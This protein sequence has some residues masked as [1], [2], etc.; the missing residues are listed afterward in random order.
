MTDFE[1]NDA[2]RDTVLPTLQ[3]HRFVEV[4]K[5]DGWIA[6]ELLYESGNRWFSTSWDWRDRYLEIHLGRLYLFQDVMPRVVVLGPLSISQRISGPAAET[7]RAL[8]QDAARRIPTLLDGF[9]ELQRAAI[10]EAWGKSS[11]G[12]TALR[13]RARQFLHLLGPEIALDAWRKLAAA[14]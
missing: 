13:K 1:L 10:A 9:D 12:E 3:E 4:A 11:A 14:Q 7:V 8:L 6:P 2:V 5:P